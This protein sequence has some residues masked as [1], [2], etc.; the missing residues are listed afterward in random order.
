MTYRPW[1]LII[2]LVILSL[3]TKAFGRKSYSVLELHD[4]YVASIDDE[5]DKDYSEVYFLPPAPPLADGGWLKRVFDD[6]T[7]SKEFRER[8]ERQFGRTEAEQIQSSPNPYV[9]FDIIT[10]QGV[11][12]GN[13]VEDQIQRQRFGEYMVRRLLEHNIDR[14]AKNEPA[15]RPLYEIKDR[16][17]RAQVSVASGYIININYSFSGNNL[18]IRFTNPYAPVEAYYEMESGHFGPSTVTEAIYSISKDLTKTTSIAT[19]YKHKDGIISLVGKRQLTA[20][21]GTSLTLSTNTHEHGTTQ[22]ENLALAG[23][24]INY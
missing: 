13:A 4:G 5:K 15:I 20:I 12:R 8:Y 1:S 7:L 21:M 11:F 3:A 23:L 10:P 14:V 24:S 2:L 16:I 18:K 19:Y 22:R 9:V 17:S 6:D